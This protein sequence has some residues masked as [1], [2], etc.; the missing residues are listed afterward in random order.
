M[1][2]SSLFCCQ[3]I[4]G[5]LQPY[6]KTSHIAILPVAKHCISPL[7][8]ILL[9]LLTG[10]GFAMQLSYRIPA[11]SMTNIRTLT[12]IAVNYAEPV[13]LLPFCRSHVS[14]LEADG[15]MIHMMWSAANNS[16]L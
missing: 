16:F 3:E 8:L 1:N 6:L 2:Y 5:D 15:A 12:Q 4:S 9:P 10:T 11:N 13:F 14:C 7:C